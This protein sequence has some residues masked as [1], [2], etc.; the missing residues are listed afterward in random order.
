MKNK[1]KY[2]YLVYCNP[3]N[4]L[5]YEVYANKQRAVKY[6]HNLIE[7][8]CNAAL[9]EGINFGYY[10]YF[11]EDKKIKENDFDKRE[12]L[13]FSACLKIDDKRE[14]SDDGCYVKVIR[15]R[16]R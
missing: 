6:A 4:P 5:V 12:K 2:V 14:F 1:P 15:R 13:I 8:R 7:W 9:K 16:L 10:H 3:D 11:K